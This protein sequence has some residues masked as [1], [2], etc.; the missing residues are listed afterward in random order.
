MASTAG[1]HA[2]RGLASGHALPAMLRWH[3]LGTRNHVSQHLLSTYCVLDVREFIE[4]TTVLAGVITAVVDWWPFP[5]W[6][7]SNTQGL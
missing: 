5:A 1:T 2:H 4:H 7:A 6:S 3:R